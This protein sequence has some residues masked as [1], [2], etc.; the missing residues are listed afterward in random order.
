MVHLHDMGES[1]HIVHLN[2][3][4]FSQ[5]YKDNNAH[6]FKVR[7]PELISLEPVG[8]WYCCVKQCSVGF[9]FSAPLYLSSDICHDSVA[10]EKKTPCLEGHSSKDICHL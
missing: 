5:T 7:L 4:S 1:N 9:H 10:G 3:A 2:S 6:D 8:E